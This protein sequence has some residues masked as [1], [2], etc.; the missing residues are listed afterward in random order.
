MRIINILILSLF[1][2]FTTTAQQKFSQK[3]FNKLKQLEGPGAMIIAR[4]DGISEMWHL[5][6]D[7]LL[8]GTLYQEDSTRLLIASMQLYY[9]QGQIKIDHTYL[10][11]NGIKGSVHSLELQSTDSG[12]YYFRNTADIT[13]RNLKEIYCSTTSYDMSGHKIINIERKIIFPI[14]RYVTVKYKFIKDE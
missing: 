5:T 10:D 11:Q 6:N 12:I 1:F 3:D 13:S 2:V 7:T 8:S 9:S 14:K 4:Q